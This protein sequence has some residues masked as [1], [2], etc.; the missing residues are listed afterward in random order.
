MSETIAV[1]SA[2]TGAASIGAGPVLAVAER[3]GSLLLHL[4]GAREGAELAA[5]L[6]VL[7][8]TSLPAIGASGGQDSAS[9][10]GIGPAIWLMVLA[11]SKLNPSCLA[12]TGSAFAASV[13]TSHAY[14]RIAISGLKADELLAKGCAVDLHPRHFPPGACATAALAGMRCIIWRVAHDDFEVFVGRSYAVSLWEWLRDVTAEYDVHPNRAE[15]R[16]IE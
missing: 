4:E 12:L 13:D 7:G 9:L 14:M 2:L 3:P 11:P 16:R 10:L 8:L 5:V 1:R 15:Y 6:S